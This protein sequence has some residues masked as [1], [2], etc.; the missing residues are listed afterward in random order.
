MKKDNLNP[1]K[2]KRLF[3]FIKGAVLGVIITLAVMLLAAVVMFFAEL[4]RA[5]AAP[6][7]TLS[8]AVGTF[9]AAFY[10]ASKIGNK[11]YLIGIVTGVAVFLLLTL[12]S[13]LINGSA[14]SFNTLFH[15]IIILL[16]SFIG[17]VMGV[18][19][20]RNKKYI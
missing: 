3:I 6:I 8:L 16:S 13:L 2:N 5:Y 19:K 9:F 17:G 15:F 14:L 1:G 10:V 12:I 7:A 18:N 11:G 4:D 20:G